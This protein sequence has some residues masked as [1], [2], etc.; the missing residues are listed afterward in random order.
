MRRASLLLSFAFLAVALASAQNKAVKTV[1]MQPTAT[2]EG[3]DSYNQYCA[4]CHGKDGKGGGPAAGALK[5]Q[6][7]D[8]TQIARRNN[9]K[10]NDLIVQN[11]INGDNSIT[12]HGSPAMPVWGELFKSVNGDA[13]ARKLRLYSLVKYIEQMQAR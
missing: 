9:G 4:V 7:A 5:K 3:V 10:F 8:L 1:P 2:L 11:A 13:S 12:A 6:P